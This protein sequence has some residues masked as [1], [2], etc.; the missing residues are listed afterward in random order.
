MS[1]KNELIYSRKRSVDFSALDSGARLGVAQA[2]LMMQ[3]TL[4]EC[5]GQMKCDGFTYNKLGYYWVL[6][7]SKVEFFRLPRWGEV[8][9]TTSFPVHNSR[10]RAY[11]NTVFTDMQ[12]HL[13]AHAFQ[14]FCVLDLEK[15]RPVPLADVP[16]PNEGFPEKAVDLEY[17]KFGLSDEDYTE[18]YT[19]LVRSG[20]LD[21][22]HH[23]NNIEYVRFALDVFSEEF[24]LAHEAEEIELHYIAES[25]EGQT[26]S[27]LRAE[28][29]SAAYIRIK[30]SERCVFEMKIRFKA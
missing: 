27:I 2:A 29:D 3:D 8:I 11:F 9:E 15:H 24:L 14:E 13:L 6:T 17:E 23:L 16:Y 30:E 19:Q 12:G 21:V 26:L 4:T 28:K 18:V 22:S 25:R 20:H 10:T 5:F 7:K 1:V